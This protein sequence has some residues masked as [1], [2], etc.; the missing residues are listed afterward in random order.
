M[1]K[2]KVKLAAPDTLIIVAACVLLVAILGWIIPSGSYE[3]QE[4]EINGR[5]RNIAINGTYQEIPKSEVTTTSFLGFFASL[6]RGCVGA[7][8][9]IFL[10][11][12]KIKLK[13]NPGL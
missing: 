2:K 3:Y 13:E 6:Y 4:M 8:D 9:I 12:C 7:A 11:L 1:D 5:I 10:I